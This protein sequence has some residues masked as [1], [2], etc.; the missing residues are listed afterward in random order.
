MEQLGIKP[1]HNNQ[2]FVASVG[3]AMKTLLNETGYIYCYGFIVG[4]L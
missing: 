1:A 3:R 2:S 4:F